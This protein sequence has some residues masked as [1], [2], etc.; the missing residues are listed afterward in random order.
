MA[1][2]AHRP[3]A[4][5]LLGLELLVVSWGCREQVVSQPLGEPLGQTA[6][7]MWTNGGFESG[8]TA[9]WTVERAY[10]NTAV[11]GS[12]VNPPT[13]QFH[14]LLNYPGLNTTSW[15][16]PVS[17]GTDPDV[18]SAVSFPRYGTYALKVN[19]PGNNYFAN[20]VTQTMT[21]GAGVRRRSFLQ[22]RHLQGQAPERRRLRS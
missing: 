4:A 17:A 10:H 18:G 20:R 19:D 14:L 3:H 1:S 21:V 5:K 6:Q 12:A 16:N 9:G 13:S 8:T 22:R 15:S 11:N 7:A 2:L